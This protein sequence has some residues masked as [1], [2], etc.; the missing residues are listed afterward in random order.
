[1]DIKP[2]IVHLLTLDGGGIRGI[3]PASILAHLEEQLQNAFNN[4]QLRIADCFDLIGGTSTGGILTCLYLTPDETDP[5]RPKY[6]AA[7]I[8]D[9]YKEYGPKLFHKSLWYKIISGLGVFRSRYSEEALCEFAHKLMGDVYISSVIKDCLITSYDMSMRKA[10]FFTKYNVNKYG[11]AADYLL[12]DIARATS[13]APTYFSPARIFARDNS[14]RHLVDGGVFA[15]NPSMCAYVESMKLWPEKS[16]KNY[17]M[18]SIGTGKVTHPYDWEKTH[19]F[20]YLQWLQPIIDVLS[21]SVG[22][23]VDFQ[24]RQIFNAGGVANNYIRMEPSLLS[25]DPRMDNASLKNIAA[26]ENAARCYIENN[27]DVFERIVDSMKNAQGF[28][29]EC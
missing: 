22:E 4:P 9:F 7:Q 25:V 13:A 12:A 8:R 21:S 3:I 2:E 27:E 10:L 17:C 23:T 20:G 5:A 19:K 18:I 28:K 16:I 1:M 15:N 26:L 11:S 24:M 29:S 6:S 14:S